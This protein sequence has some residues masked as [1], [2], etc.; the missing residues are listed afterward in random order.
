V[1]VGA[2]DT[3]AYGSS[4]AAVVRSAGAGSSPPVPL[5]AVATS[6]RAAGG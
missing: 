4:A 5:H 6:A 2:S 3:I 1:V